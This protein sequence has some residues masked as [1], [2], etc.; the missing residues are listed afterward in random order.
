MCSFP[1]YPLRGKRSLPLSPQSHTVRQSGACF[2]PARKWRNSYTLR[3]PRATFALPSNFCNPNLP[4]RK[5]YKLKG[6]AAQARGR[7]SAGARAAQVARGRR[8]CC[9]PPALLYPSLKNKY[10]CFISNLQYVEHK[11]PSRCRLE[12]RTTSVLVLLPPFSV[13]HR[14]HP[15]PPFEV[16][17]RRE[18]PPFAVRRR[19]AASSFCSSSTPP[20][21]SSFC[22]TSSGASSLCSTSLIPAPP[23]PPPSF[24]VRRRPLL[25]YHLSLQ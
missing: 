16:R 11:E 10:F 22:S 1:T 15:L 6:A 3:R 7:R 20:S 25:H 14:H 19:L 5:H 21:S 13:R 4:P 17:R 12:R 9:L 23:P 2:G 18:L 8:I 24:A